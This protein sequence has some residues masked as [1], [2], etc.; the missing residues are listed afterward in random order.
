MSEIKEGD[1]V[2][3]T[4]LARVKKTHLTV[5]GCDRRDHLVLALISTD[6]SEVRIPSVVHPERC[7]LVEPN[8]KSL[9][10]SDQ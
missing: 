10:G 8:V 1:L 4:F 5:N 7:V 9:S 2:D 3:V 6:G